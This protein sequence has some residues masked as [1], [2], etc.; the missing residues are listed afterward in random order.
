VVDGAA[1]A[2]IL[3]A[4]G[5]RLLKEGKAP[6]CADP[7]NDRQTGKNEASG[8][9]EH[10]DPVPEDCFSYPLS[11]PVRLRLKRRSNPDLLC[12]GQYFWLFCFCSELCPSGFS[13]L[14]VSSAFLGV[15]AFP[16]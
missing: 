12:F 9:S 16:R 8:V 5:N 11:S 15:S 4:N 10:L 3:A 7:D 1:I 6:S 13:P 2:T 14:T